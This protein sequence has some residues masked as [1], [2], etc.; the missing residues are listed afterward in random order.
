MST[1]LQTVHQNQMV[2]APPDP[3]ADASPEWLDKWIEHDGSRFILDV[4]TISADPTNE[5]LVA[6]QCLSLG[7]HWQAAAYLDLMR[8]HGKPC[9]AF[10][11]LFVKTSPPHT[12]CLWVLNDNDIE[13]G[14][15]RNRIALLD[16]AKRLKSG[17]WT[18]PRHGEVNYLTYPK[19]AMDDDTH[20]PQEDNT[21]VYNEFAAYAGE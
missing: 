17:E 16:L 14:Q 9:D 2:S 6:Q 18:G 12:A 5:R 10:F 7:Y 8:G 21:A 13:L 20:L 1:D 19:W 15:R 3:L 4:K 11:F